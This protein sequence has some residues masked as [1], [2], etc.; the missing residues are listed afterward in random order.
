MSNSVTNAG[1]KEPA[2]TD[3]VVTGVGDIKSSTGRM[4][5]LCLGAFT[6]WA[7]VFPLGSAVV[8][9]GNVVAEGNN[10]LVQHRQG[11]MI[12]EIYAKNGDKVHKGD[13]I[14]R[15]DPV[16]DA[17]EAGKLKARKAMLEAVRKRLMSEQSM[18]AD[19]TASIAD[20]QLRG[21]DGD[22]IAPAPQ[23][24]AAL[25]INPTVIDA[26]QQQFE[27]GRAALQS[28]I[29]ELIANRNAL[30]NRIEGLVAQ[31]QAT[32][33]E[34][35]ITRKQ[36]K[37]VAELV[38]GG[39]VAR[40][41]LWDLQQQQY[42][43]ESRAA[44]LQSE[45]RASRDEAEGLDARISK[46]QSADAQDNAKQLTDTLGELAQINEQLMAADSAVALTAVRA[47]VDGTVVHNQF[48]TVGGVIP[49]GEALAEIVPDNA[50]LMVRA[51]ISPSD[52]GH[53]SKGQ[54]ARAK[55]T[56]VNSRLYDDIEGEVEYVA[57]DSTMEKQT[58]QQYFDVEVRLTG[59][60]PAMR[61]ELG[62]S[63]GM[64]GEV[65]IQGQSRTFASYALKP[66]VDSLS[67]AF[68]EK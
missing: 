5:W 50:P 28:E 31:A 45:A 55:I 41:T 26:Q 53:V 38:S 14:F 51:R 44:S 29:N 54:K 42:D 68:Q 27:N 33:S 61:T 12:A 16:V 10:K 58:G 15:L 8:G 37:S 47:P 52:I 30:V 57:A 17:A 7:L 64:Q 19:V 21:S 9:H 6:V 11:G 66:F 24:E 3:G 36:V 2:W 63:S 25:N 13:I 65:F 39:H 67:R 4:V 62:I 60:S 49:A 40:K 59:L 46:L 32:E 23:N 1:A 48:T 22:A 56:S 43:M 34:L 35:A 20:A 18:A